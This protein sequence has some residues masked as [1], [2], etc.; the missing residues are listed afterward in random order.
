MREKSHNLRF[1]NIMAQKSGV[2]I[3]FKFEKGYVTPT[4]KLWLKIAA[5]IDVPEREAPPTTVNTQAKTPS[6][7]AAS[8]R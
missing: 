3:R 1:L 6:G 2:N 5:D 7:L 8:P 4:L